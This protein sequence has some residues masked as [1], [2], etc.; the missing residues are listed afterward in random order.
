MVSSARNALLTGLVA[1]VVLLAIWLMTAGADR[2]VLIA[3]L[4]RALH[5][6]GAML[7]VGMIVFVNLI[8]IPALAAADDAGRRTLLQHVV[9]KVA[10]TFAH[11]SHLVLLTGLSLLFSAGYLTRAAAGQGLP[12]IRHA[13]LWLAVLGGLAMW[14]IVHFRIRPALR[15]VLGGETVA[16][17]DRQAAREG[18]HLWARVNLAL[19]L[20]VTVLMVA[21]PHLY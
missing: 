9:P 3:F 6:L 5:V 16:P 14:A 2:T 13:M 21:A 8:Q 15:I 12:P 7:W 10:S 4:A 19:S 11:A 20:P 18:V 17:A 1:T